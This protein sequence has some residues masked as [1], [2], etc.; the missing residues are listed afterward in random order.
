VSLV[1]APHFLLTG[2]GGREGLFRK[3]RRRPTTTT[4]RAIWS[5]PMHMYAEKR[6]HDWLWKC[7]ETIP[8]QTQSVTVQLN[9][10]W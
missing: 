5:R 7:H 4:W 1:L 10:L 9:R 8:Y 3:R 6:R 2:F